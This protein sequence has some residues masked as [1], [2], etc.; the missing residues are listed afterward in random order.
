M[1]RGPGKQMSEEGSSGPSFSVLQDGP[2]RQGWRMTVG[3]GSSHGLVH[4]NC[5]SKAI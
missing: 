3:F 2:T 1:Y 4:W 5:L